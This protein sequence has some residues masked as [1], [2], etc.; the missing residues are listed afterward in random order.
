MYAIMSVN[1]Y[2]THRYYQHAEVNKNP[3]FKAI[4]S[5][6]GMEKVR[7]GGHVEHHAGKTINCY[8]KVVTITTMS[9]RD[10]R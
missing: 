2:V 4:S 8:M 3:I 6:F 10:L 9:R 1:E 5:I 7:G